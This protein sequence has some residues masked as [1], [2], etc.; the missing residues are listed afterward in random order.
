MASSE[1][2]FYV[3]ISIL[4]EAST[5][6]V[7]VLVSSIYLFISSWNID[8]NSSNAGAEMQN[9]RTWWLQG[10]ALTASLMWVEYV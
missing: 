1:T 2:D 3:V 4:I 8:L 5:Y 10:D 9:E 6:A 7:L